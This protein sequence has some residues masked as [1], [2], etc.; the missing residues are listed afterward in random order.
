MATGD[1]KSTLKDIADHTKVSRH[2]GKLVIEIPESSIVQAASSCLHD[3]ATVTDAE[4][5]LEHVARHL[6]SH[7]RTYGEG[8]ESALHQLI[9]EVLAEAAHANVGLQW[10]DPVQHTLLHE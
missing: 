9:G 6:T 7:Q 10:K 8:R 3:R 2:L 5:M 1:A 4:R